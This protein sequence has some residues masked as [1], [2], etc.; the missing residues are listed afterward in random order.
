[1]H[2]SSVVN[3][4]SNCSGIPYG[5]QIWPK[6][7]LNRGLHFA[8]VKG[9]AGVICGHP[10]VSLPRNYLWT[11]NLVRRT[12]DQCEVHWWGQ[13]SQYIVLVNLGSILK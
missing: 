3:Q 9:H 1:M 11:L 2:G 5:H 10:E 13:R 7:P 6:E 4:K 12:I 8:R